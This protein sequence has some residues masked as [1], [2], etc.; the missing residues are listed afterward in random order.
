MSERIISRSVIA[1]LALVAAIAVAV[2]GCSTGV[3]KNLYRGSFDYAT[4]SQL[5]PGLT[6]DKVSEIIQFSPNETRTFPAPEGGADVISALEFNEALEEYRG[7]GKHWLL[8]KNNKLAAE[9]MG[10][11]REAEM[12]WFTAHYDDL[13]DNGVIGRAEAERKKYQKLQQLYTTT[14]YETEY[15]T[16][17]IVVAGQLDRKEID[18]DTANYLL[19]KKKN[20]VG[21]KLEIAKQSAYARE[22][23][24]LQRSALFLQAMSTIQQPVYVQGSS[25]G[26]TATR[27]GN[28]WFA[29]CY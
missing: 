25:T 19:A 3:G 14:P 11:A 10:G 9:G 21:A 1:R 20:D 15:F 5:K 23:V 4:K 18:N 27:Y 2:E 28:T 29:N 22:L 17:R 8:F 12:Y 7:L 26:C 6:I 24:S 13:R 16:Y